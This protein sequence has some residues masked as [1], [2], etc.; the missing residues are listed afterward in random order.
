M[1]LKL[2][3]LLTLFMAFVMQ[4]SFGQEKDITGTV[5]AASDGL[6]LPG[7]TVLVKGTARGTQTDFDGKYSIKAKSGDV[8]VFSFVSMKTAE[9]T[10]GAAN[11]IDLAMADDVAA[12]DEVVIT[13]YSTSS[14]K[15]SA[16]ASSKVTSETI[17]NRPN[18]SLV[19]TLTGQIPGLDI[20]TNSGQPGANSLVQLRGVNSINGNT[21]PL[22]LI[23]GV[24][25]NE[26]NF[27][28]LNANEIESVDVLKDAGAT[29]IYGSR[30]ANG[31]VVI[32]TRRGTKDSTLKVNY[33]GILS[34]ATLQ[35]NRYDL[36]NTRQALEL[37][38][39]Y[40]RARGAGLGNGAQTGGNVLFPGT[41]SP[42]TDAEIAQEADFDWID[43]FFRTGVTENHTITLSSGSANASQFTSIG[44]FNQ[45]GILNNSN[46]QR[47]NFR[48]NINGSS[49]NGK[50]NYGTSI[51]VNYSK[52][53]QLTSIGTNGVN[54][55]P[56]FGALSSLPYFTPDDQPTSQQLANDFFIEYAPFYITDKLN[57]SD[58]LD[59]E[60]KIIAGL[61]AS[62]KITDDIT[63]T[64]NGGVDYQNVVLLNSQDPI[65]RNQLRFNPAVDG[66]AQQ[67][68]DRQF[69]FQSTTSLNWNK[70]FGKH[71]FGLGGYL[72]YF[73]AHRRSFGFVA[74]GLDPATFVPQDD[75][76][77]LADT[78]D[79]DARVDT[80]SATKSDA[81]LLSYFGAF[82]YDFDS[83]YG[84]NAVVRRDASYRFATTN[85]WATFWSIAGRW[86]ISNES[87]MDDSVFQDLKL[88]ASYG[89]SGNQRIQGNT[90]W[91]GAD[92]P[93]NF[94]TLL[95]GYG[96]ADA[97]LFNQ[98]GNNE[99][100]WETVAQL[101]VGVDFALFDSRLR[102][103]IDVYE[104]ETTDLFQD[105]PISGVNGQF[106]LRANTGTL[107]N[108]GVDVALNYDLV[109]TSDLNVGVQ[110]VG[111]YNQTELADLPS[112]DGE[113]I[114]IGR[115]GG[116]LREIFT[117]RYAGVNPATGNL[118]YLDRNN[119]LTEDPNVD[120]DR[121]WTDRNSV[122]DFTGSF[123]INVDYKGW[124]LQTQMQFEAGRDQFDNDY[125]RF[126]NPDVIG[127]FRVSA[128]F[129]RAWQQPGDVTDIPSVNVN[130]DQFGSDRF[131]TP[132]DFIRLR[133]AQF[134]YNFPAKSLETTGI[135]SLRLF[136]NAENLFT[137][138][139]FRGFDAASRLNG[140]EYPTPRILSFGVE[141]GF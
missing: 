37:E 35:D 66:F 111:N 121:V 31:V 101:N 12:L 113:I 46:L 65:S 129:L 135:S 39:T 102:G 69:S 91:S 29:A 15:K 45:E 59:E 126:L 127:Q 48:N 93:F 75:A 13:G 20:S 1:K 136:M 43:F 44:Y 128:D 140:L 89:T 79:D 119:N 84:L 112:E 40:G 117:L 51:S 77:F 38:R 68:S 139:E 49:S 11:T 133:F 109:R 2:T 72:E 141:L 106:T 4:L 107:K 90:Y 105:Q 64:F 56:L 27:R 124:F 108:R 100:K 9:R 23:D 61:N 33:V 19:Q 92:L 7:V 6:P 132:M 82:D 115:N 63:A 47:F 17:E 10:V 96:G 62:Y 97:I 36:V 110:L 122:P 131:L 41:G 134:G 74:N 116:K 58:R 114:G 94:F 34:Y 76:G 138:S 81:G 125:S 71:T 104:K 8:L 14:K 137:L 28:S 86:N 42:L 5:T 54:Q 70:Q 130:N 16:I 99:L 26:D 3:W 85:R 22:F 118:L 78:P 80:V 73:K 103:S 24:P 123:N 52:S 55:N 98:L 21:E 57:T 120:L 50:F 87:F 32:K 83:K 88:R 18:A 25:V 67:N 60:L 30:G 53:D 95:Q